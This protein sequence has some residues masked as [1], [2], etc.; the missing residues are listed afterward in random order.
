MAGVV[1]NKSVGIFRGK[2]VFLTGDTGFKGSWLA[3][4]LSELGAD[5]VG[6]ALP[7][8]GPQDHFCLLGLDKVIHHVDGDIR[9]AAGL[10]AVLHEFAPEFVFHLA[11]QSLVR[12]SYD[13]PKLTFDTNVT[14]TVNLLEAVR[15]TPSVCSLV[16]ITSDKC[17][18]NKEWVWGYRETDALGGPDPYS[19]SK[20]AAENICY[21]YARSYFDKRITLGAATTR[22]GNVI[23]GGDWAADRIVP[24]A[25][26]ALSQEGPLVL[27]NPEST[28]PWQHVLEPLGGYLLLAARLYESPQAFSGSW[29]FGPGGDSNR[30][31]R[32]LSEKI[33]AAWGGG[34]IVEENRSSA[35]HE[36]KLLQ[37]NCDKA[38]VLLGW[39]PRWDFDTTVA[40]TASWYLRVH[41]GDKARDVSCGQIAAYM[42]AA[43]TRTDW[44]EKE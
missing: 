29:N 30:T 37:L 10:T 19:A 32:E 35:P 6:Y 22:A 36:A 24:D 41:A 44:K 26:R 8:Q 4:W 43:E 7:P 15:Y 11:A 28:R 17:Y 31:V 34:R 33:V 1:N 25:I 14:G 23:G 39:R 40:Q 12:L 3:L 18:L 16:T 9:D 13:E 20:A 2:R 27:R 42:E 38:L 5:V 21:A